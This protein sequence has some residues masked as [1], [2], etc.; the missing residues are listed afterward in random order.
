MTRIDLRKFALRLKI[1]EMLKMHA[2]RRMLDE[3]A[4]YWRRLILPN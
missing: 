2:R 4:E 3:A 1:V